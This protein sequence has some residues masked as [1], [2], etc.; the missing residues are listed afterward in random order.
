M[1]KLQKELRPWTTIK[2]KKFSTTRCKSSIVTYLYVI[3]LFSEIR[4]HEKQEKYNA[5]Y[6]GRKLGKSRC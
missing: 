1:C 5:K 3:K 6:K 4:E 2:R